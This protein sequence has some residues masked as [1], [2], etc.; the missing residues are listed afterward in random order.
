[1]EDENKTKHQLINELAQM[2]Q[3]ITALEEEHKLVEEAL[4]ISE[5][6][7]HTVADFT[8]DWEYWISVDGHCQYVSPSCERITGY[9]PDE[10]RKDPELLKKITHADDKDKI[11]THLRED[12][13]NAKPIHL[14]FHIITRSDEE[15]WI[16]HICQPVHGLRGRYLG[17]RASNL[18]ITHC[19]LAARELRESEE[20]YRRITEAI[21]DYIFTVRVENGLP[22][23]TVHGPACQAV[24][25]YTPEEFSSDPYL[26]IRM[27]P[28]EDRDVVRKQASHI[29]SGRD[30]E[31]VEHRIVRKDGS[32][33][34]V[35]N[36][37]VPHHDVRGNLISYDGLIRDI[38]ERKYAEE[39]L[40][41]S[42][43]NYRLLVDNLPNVVF[44]GYKD[45]SVEFVD[46]KIELLTGY[47]KEEFNCYKKKW[48]DLVVKEDIQRIKKIF[49]EAL[50]TDRSYVREYRIRTK[51]GDILW[52]EEGGQIVCDKKGKFKLVAGA[53][54]DITE[55]KRIEKKIQNLAYYDSITRLPNRQLFKEY[56]SRTLAYAKRHNRLLA[57]LFLDLDFFK[58]V[59][60]SFG[61][62]GGDLLS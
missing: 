54:S 7:F 32:I 29:V 44:R 28:E 19:K 41:E 14:D 23:E 26:W 61:H 10:F 8:Y 62:R 16:A 13:E 40:K 9:R 58:N 53:F 50:K 38:T 31:P 46:D 4:R 33:R 47:K 35:S 55:R 36:T 39:A 21:T 3:R 25:G 34:W 60:D 22:V 11:D 15:R 2:R 20:R 49:I 43:T 24:T 56:M 27:V 6:R 37:P 59:N 18:D 5:E 17:R 12:L 42:E 1:M 51:T 48:A 57:T 30:L 45:W 52:I